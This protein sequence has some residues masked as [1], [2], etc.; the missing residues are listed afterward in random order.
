MT[1]EEVSR[2]ALEIAVDASWCAIECECL[3]EADESGEWMF[4]DSAERENCA[5]QVRLLEELNLLG[6]HPSKPGW[7]REIA[8]L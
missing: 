5:D 4:L 2:L 6:H 7:V 3:H 1:Q 8:E